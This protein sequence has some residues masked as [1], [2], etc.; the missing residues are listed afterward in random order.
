M[1]KD[2]LT[3]ILFVFFK[4]ATGLE[5]ENGA[6]ISNSEKYPPML[7]DPFSSGT[8]WIIS[9]L[10]NLMVDLETKNSE[11]LLTIEK[12]FQNGTKL[13]FS[14]CSEIDSALLPLIYYKNSL[15]N[16]QISPNSK[17]VLAADESRLIIF[18]NR[19]LFCNPNFEIYFE[20]LNPFN[21][22][23]PN[24]LTCTTP[25][26]FDPSVEN[27]IDQFQLSLFQILFP[28]EYAKRNLVLKHIKECNKK[29]VQ[30]DDITKAKWEKHGFQVDNILHTKLAL[31]RKY[32]IGQ[33]LEYCQE[34]LM[35]I[36]E[37]MK[38]LTPLAIR[39]SLLMTLT[40]K[41][42]SISKNYEFSV[43]LIEFIFINMSNLCKDV[44]TQELKLKTQL[45]KDEISLDNS[46]GSV[47]T[48]EKDSIESELPP[49]E[50]IEEITKQ[51]T[52]RIYMQD[53]IETLSKYL[54]NSFLN[55]I[56]LSL[57]PEHRLYLLT[58]ISF[59]IKSEQKCDF[60]DL[61]LEFLMRGKYNSNI[62][63]ALT[64]FGVPKNTPIPKW[65]PPDKWKD[66]L[67]MSL[68]Q[69]ELDHFVVAIVSSEKE[70]KD[71]YSN[72]FSGQM[73][74]IEME[75]EKTLSN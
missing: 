13:L 47:N 29:L 8:N 75:I 27:F 73:P 6:I 65:I 5:M 74:K 22:F 63:I 56:I 43:N 10:T 16:P 33:V 64:D 23:S 70:W 60:T 41:M 20:T 26:S 3:N 68:L 2:I 46:S 67:A 4:D 69:G 66:L 55:S 14:N 19:R 58:L 59:Y 30:I 53:D 49:V 52:I 28:D 72:P 61:E 37:T 57:L 17:A 34:Y 12:S 44:K 48:I 1:T 54:T 36:N 62:N 24:L 11:D 18:S 7:Y 9:K 71:W 21:T 50:N 42:T 15:T 32:K 38:V 51:N 39:A 40:L 35:I 31:Q 25:I 45:V